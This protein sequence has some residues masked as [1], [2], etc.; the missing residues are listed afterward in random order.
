MIRVIV[1]ASRKGGAGKTTLACHL[2]VEAERV[3]AGPV[4][5]VDTDD[6]RGMSQW[7]D[8]RKASTPVLFNLGP[9][10]GETAAALS[11]DGFALLIVDTPPA[12]S[13]AVAALVADADLIIVP[14]RASPD[15]L[16]AIGGTVQLI[17][18]VRKPLTFVINAT[19]PRARLSG[20]AAVALNQYGTVCPIMVADRTDYAGAKV[21]GRTAPEL[22]TSGPAAKEIAELW[23]YIASRLEIGNDI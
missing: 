18:R 15:D 5:L 19:K 1:L 8:A 13:A 14:V 10:L 16:R 2:A 23:K 7:W 21:D 4:A 12:I 22:N 6:M 17:N 9:T 3:G 11:Q 20:E